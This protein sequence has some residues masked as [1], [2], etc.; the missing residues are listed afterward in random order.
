MKHWHTPGHAPLSNLREFAK[1]MKPGK[2]VP[3]HFFEPD[4][5]LENSENVEIKDDGQWWTL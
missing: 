3:I 4:L 1:A 2:L 5:Y